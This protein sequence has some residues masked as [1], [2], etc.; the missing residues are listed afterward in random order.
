MTHAH[1]DLTDYQRTRAAAA[2]LVAMASDRSP[3]DLVEWSPWLEP[4][5][6]PDFDPQMRK[7][8]LRCYALLAWQLEAHCS[9]YGPH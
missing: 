2:H 9:V 5:L 6:D 1:S 7:A 4:F 3:P 8:A